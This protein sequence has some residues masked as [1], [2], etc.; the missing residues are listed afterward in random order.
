MAEEDVVTTSKEH[1]LISEF[2]RQPGG[3]PVKYEELLKVAEDLATLVSNNSSSESQTAVLGSL[4]KTLGEEE[5]ETT[6]LRCLLVLEKILEEG[7][8]S[9]NSLYSLRKI[10]ERLKSSESQQVSMKAAKILDI[11][12]HLRS[13]KT[14]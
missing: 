10:L 13:S 9:I 2:C 14:A 11:L 7:I 5:A 6:V 4:R 12:E 8:I 3:L 1:Q